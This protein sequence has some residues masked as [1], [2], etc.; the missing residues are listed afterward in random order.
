MKRKITIDDVAK[1]A[2]VSRSTV[3]QFLN[4]RFEYMSTDTRIKI[5]DTI[6]ALDYKPN[7][8]ARSLK[9]KNTST[10]GVIVANIMHAYS[11]QV[12]RAIENVCNENGFSTIICNADDDSKK[13][14]Q[15]IETL[16]AKQ[17]DGLIVV[18]I[19]G[20]KELYKKLISQN[21]PI[22]FL[23]RL[24]EGLEVDTVLLDNQKASTLAVDHLIENG[25]KKIAIATTS[26]LDNVS[27]RVERING[28]ISALKVNNIPLRPD[29]IQGL[30]IRL[31]RKGLDKLF[32]LQDPPDAIISGNDLTLMEILR[33]T[34]ENEIKIGRDIGLITIDE[35]SFG[36]IHTP[37]LTTIAQP[38]LEMGTKVAK[39]LLNKIKDN[40][41][42]TDHEI[43]RFEPTLIIRKSTMKEDVRNE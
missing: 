40:K 22:V 37:P 4:D 33:Y 39:I 10:I 15:Y 25:Y 3:S 34:F 18:P 23:D 19:N 12:I 35:V 30:E 31:L 43:H 1:Q 36:A 41:T 27:P 21:Y 14:K 16:L 7:V 9:K 26:L 13:E 20:N 6:A 5:E 28:Y 11:T 24:I 2:G 29:Y 38:T 8:I 17:V 42:K 32:N